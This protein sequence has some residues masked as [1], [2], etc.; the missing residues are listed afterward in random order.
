MEK[1]IDLLWELEIAESN[2]QDDIQVLAYLEDELA[3]M[4]L[5]EIKY[6]IPELKNRVQLLLKSMIYNKEKMQKVVEEVYQ[7]KKEGVA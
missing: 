3:T 2:L 5:N 1:E 7:Q 6:F 4:D